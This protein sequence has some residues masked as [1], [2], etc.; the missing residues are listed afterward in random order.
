MDSS[1]IGRYGTLSLLKRLQPDSVVASYPIDDPEITVGRDPTCSIRLYY[2][3]VSA[4]HCKIV[5]NDRKAFL[6]VLGTN[7]VLVDGC[8]VFP[9]APNAQGPTTVP[10]PN[11]ATLDI[12]KKSFRFAYPPRHLRPALLATPEKPRALRLSMIHSAQVFSPR[13]SPNPSENLRVLQ[14]PLKTAFQPDIVLVESD[15][16]RVVEEDRDLIILDE[17]ERVQPQPQQLPLPRPPT[18]PKTPVRR[19][20]RPSLHREVLIRSAHRIEI[21]REIQLEEE[22]EV[23]ETIADIQE[24]E[25]ELEEQ[26]E[27][28]QLQE[29]K[30]TKPVSSWRKSL[31]AVRGSL[32]WALR[33]V[34]M[35][36]KEEEEEQTIYWSMNMNSTIT[37]ANTK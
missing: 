16:P 6:V 20:P 30:E 14:S 35:E 9:A 19:R 5:F 22:A 29:G 10:L 17:V 18:F 8:P 25:E 34:S 1:D 37:T 31:D 21:Q 36:P 13:P 33:A 2:P 27:E 4:L 23:E 11:G 26:E 3:S 32:E 12:H 15:S 24:E 7:G 28:M